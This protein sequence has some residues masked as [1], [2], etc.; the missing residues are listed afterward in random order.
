MKDEPTKS[1]WKALYDA[2]VK[3][4]TVSCWDWM[5]DSDVFAIQNPEDGEIGYC[6]VLGLEGEVY[7][8]LVFLG[9]E[10][11][12]SLMQIY[13]GEW[14]EEDDLDYL[15]LKKCISVTFE[16]REDLK[17][18]DLEVIKSLGYRFR[19]RN[20]W[21][22]FRRHD[23]GYCPWYLSAA[24][25]RFLTIALEQAVI[26]SSKFREGEISLINPGD[27]EYILLRK[28]LRGKDRLRWRNDWLIPEPLLKEGIDRLMFDEIK[29]KRIQG[30]ADRSGTWEIDTFFAPIPVKGSDDRP[31]YPVLLMCLD[32]ETAMIVGTRVFHPQMY[33]VDMLDSLLDIIDEL[34]IMPVEI[35]VRKEKLYNFFEPL[36]SRLGIKLTHEKDLLID[37]AKRLFLDEFLP[38]E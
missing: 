38:V 25:V 22:L 33:D 7:G 34:G 1:E 19:G 14:L 13:A 36:T 15:F 26:V 21:P 3:Y 16:D 30:S 31:Y 37:G 28:P 29:A 17:R 10:G 8:L 20:A 23:P 2:V 5:Y 27:A 12:A 11:F 32:R 35:M 6:S 4:K 9:E 24:D 18:K